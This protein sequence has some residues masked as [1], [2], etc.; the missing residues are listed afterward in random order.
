MKYRLLH[1]STYDYESPV[2]YA[3]HIVRKRPRSLPNQQVLTSSITSSPAPSWSSQ[4][5]DCHGNLMDVIE[6]LGSHEQL[7]VTALTELTVQGIT[8]DPTRNELR[9]RWETAR[10]RIMGDARCFDAWEMTMLSPF[11]PHVSEVKRYAL[12]S[13]Q[14]GRSLFE[15]AKELNHRIFTDYTYDSG[16]S[17]IATPLEKVARERRG[18]CQDF[19]HVFVGAIRSLGLA[20]RYVSGYLETLPPP[21]QARLVGAD[22]SHA[23]ASVYIP[24]YGWVDFDPTNDMLPHERHIVVGWGRDFSEVSPLRGV[25]HGGGR[26]TV[27]VSVDVAPV[28]T[29]IS[30]MSPQQGFQYQGGGGQQQQ[31]FV[32]SSGSAPPSNDETH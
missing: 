9:V 20:A 26:H 28:P 16:F 3:R 32:S 6:L 14:P 21:G 19:A 2:F 8:H 4:E 18:V 12:E 15:A 31:G 27:N 17:D 24:D 22:A 29:T 1:S 5:F 13:F 23:W 10:D 30:Q 11:V 7:V 25:V